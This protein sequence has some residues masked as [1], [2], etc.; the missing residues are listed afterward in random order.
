MKTASPL[1]S[2]LSLPGV[3]LSLLAFP[4]ALATVFTTG[5]GF[6][7]P[8]VSTVQGFTSVTLLLSST[9]NDQLSKVFI[10]FSSISL[11]SQSGKTVNL[12]TATQNNGALAGYEFIHLNGNVEPLVTAIVPQDVY[13][14][15][16]VTIV[17][18]SYMS[19]VVYN[20]PSNPGGL[21]I[22]VNTPF[23][24]VQGPVPLTVNV[25]APITITGT[26]MGISLNMLLPQSALSA[27]TDYG[28]VQSMPTFNLT[29]VTFSPQPT[30][31][32][33]GK[34]TNLDGQISLVDTASNR[35]TLVL[36][37]GQTLYV[38]SNDSTVYQGVSGFSAL[39]AGM[40]VDM[41]AAI[42]WD[43]SQLA[44]RIAVVDADTTNLTMETGPVL[45]MAASEPV[46]NA[47]VRQQQG[48]LSGTPFPLGL[49]TPFSV[50]NAVYQIS[51]QFTNLQDLPFPATFD[52]ANIF[53]GQNVYITT[54]ALTIGNYPTYYPASTITLMPQTI[55]GTV[56][57]AS[58]SGAFQIYS[59]SLASYDLPTILATQ[60]GQ[61]YTLDNPSTVEV[62][63]DSDTQLL[64]KQPLAV[65]GLFRFNGLLFNDA[66]TMRMD[67]GEV[68][69]G[70]AE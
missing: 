20:A 57:G 52:A 59:V 6:S 45:L 44:T 31:S 10:A 68:N 17:Y 56:F 43:G 58:S 28:S 14:S 24:L 33:N 5:C 27:C 60:P 23:T 26:A 3:S 13:T 42:Q 9:T 51:G 66:G 48:Y 29:P 12:Y 36:A 40:F 41:D 21:T 4:L 70:V 34:E 18:S 35:F 69:D 1:H 49:V 2:F 50:T 63:V 11:T 65:G 67:C 46:L 53:G 55:N 37:D 15:A 25:P 7:P 30:N 22:F 39:T 19:C 64:N 16:T 54:H 47:F 8:T 61:S 62:Y 38:K 32:E